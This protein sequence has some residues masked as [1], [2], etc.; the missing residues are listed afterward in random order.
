MSATG[1][2]FFDVDRT[3]LAGASGLHLVRPFRK[4][5]LLTARQLA[6]T[7]LVGLAFA[8]QGSDDKQL[9]K[10]TEGVKTLMAG[11]DR[12]ML[13]EVVE[14]IDPPRLRAMEQ[15]VFGHATPRVVVVTTPNAE[16]NVRYEGLAPG[17]MRH[18]DHRFE[19]TRAEFRAWADG[20]AAAHGWDGVCV[21]GG[22]IA[23]VLLLAIVVG[24]WTL[25]SAR[26]G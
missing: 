16:H 4:R 21:L 23:V 15:V 22:G 13:M 9:D 24:E 11:W 14:H 26:V 2:A 7:L 3:L 6:H 5:G 1:A 25:R 10:F 17:A 8:A 12:E 19:W 18:P 20:V